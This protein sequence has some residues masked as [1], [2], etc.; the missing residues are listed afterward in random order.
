[1]GGDGQVHGV[2]S[3]TLDAAP[4]SSIGRPERR[5]LDQDVPSDWYPGLTG[6]RGE[7]G[8]LWGPAANQVDIL[9]PV[10]HAV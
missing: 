4:G 2:T 5:C 10:L 9:Y 6:L 1:V 7:P 8:L 3:L